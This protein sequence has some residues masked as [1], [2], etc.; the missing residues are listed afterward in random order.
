MIKFRFFKAPRWLI[1]SLLS[2]LSLL[3]VVVLTLLLF[4]WD[5]LRE[6]F[7]RYASEQL[8][9]R[10]EIT[11]HL[12]VDLG[13]SITVKL[14]G[15][16]VANPEWAK[17]PYLIKA[18]SAEFEMRLWPLLQGRLELPRVLLTQPEIGLQMQADGRR[19]WALSSDTSDVS[20]V[21]KVGALTIS[22]GLLTY[23]DSAKGADISAEF[24][25]TPEDNALLPLLYKADGKWH[26]QRFKATGRS[27]GVLQLSR[28]LQ[29]PFPLEINVITANTR[30]KAKGS[31]ANLAD[32]SGLMTYFEIEGRNLAELYQLSGVVLPSTP[33]YK[34]KGQLVRQG[35]RWTASQIDGL[36]GS[37]DLSGSLSF[38]TSGSVARLSGKLQSKLLDFSDLAPVVGLAPSKTKPSATKG[39]VNT[40]AAPDQSQVRVSQTKQNSGR[41]VLPTIP[42]DLERLKAMN[43]DVTYSA[44]AIRHVKQL[45]LDSGTVHVQLT[46]GVL[47]LDPLALGVAG[48]LLSG[49]MTIDANQTPAV[50]DTHFDV[51]GL[52]LNR[53]FPTLQSTKS[54]LGKV[55][56]QISLAGK[57]NTAASMLGSASGNL[58]LVVGRGELSNILLEFIG[59]DGGEVIKFL[60]RGDRNV[61]LR[62]AAVE[63]S[64]KQGLMT[65]TTLMLDTTDTLITGRGSVNLA[66]E[67]LDMVFNPE[68]KDGSILS[69]RS[70][71]KIAGSFA[72]PTVGV[73]KLALAGRIGLA[74]GLGLIN[75]LL[76]LA[77]T[78]ETGPGQDA[79]C[80]QALKAASRQ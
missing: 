36:L 2:A 21:P 27:G 68:P 40:R 65:S 31:V 12:S 35:N 47:Q 41:R 6:P 3:L 78:V 61:M 42:L 39:S 60:L 62:C 44:V 54:S 29:Q 58:A 59:L 14:D 49:R 37:S 8:G 19:T 55:T 38:D 50:F 26:N 71:L 77:A 46:D 23:I 72:A 79:D 75:P 64:V 16:V 45:P 22:Q 1:V 48:G 66:N 17:N 52:K 74:I 15:L 24:S 30:L 32:L 9:R 73:D 10:F 4:P 11:R 70:P 53:L 20:A 69:L 67:S 43:A 51:R 56:G 25:L 76:A 7:N 63:F 80:R 33:A 28:N 13:R 34:L 5:R 18:E 57:G